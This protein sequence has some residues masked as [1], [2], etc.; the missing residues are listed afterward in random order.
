MY[1]GRKLRH[2]F[3]GK[4]SKNY[5]V[6]KERFQLASGIRFV[7]SK[8]WIQVFLSVFGSINSWLLCCFLAA[9]SKN[10]KCSKKY[11]VAKERLQLASSIRFVCSIYGSRHFRGFML[12]K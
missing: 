2:I 1:I 10:A 7:C 11:C 9:C 5:S 12:N 6:E 8:I 4:Y 3:W